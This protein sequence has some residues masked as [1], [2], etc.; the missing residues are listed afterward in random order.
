MI[1]LLFNHSHYLI[2]K[3]IKFIVAHHTNKV[4][5]PGDWRGIYT[6]ANTDKPLRSS[7]CD[8]FSL[9]LCRPASEACEPLRNP[10]SAS[11][12]SAI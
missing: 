11:D 10:G 1:K 3:S 2:V 6:T 5:S 7:I 8:A 4:D 12:Y 9:F